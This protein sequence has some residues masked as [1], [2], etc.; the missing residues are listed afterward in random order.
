MNNLSKTITRRMARAAS[1][2]S[3]LAVAGWTGHAAAG[4]ICFPQPMFVPGLSG[5]PTWATAPSGTPSA[6]VLTRPDLNEPRW[7]SSPL[8][9][10]L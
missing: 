6:G 9:D 2:A 7:A 3:F 4:P 10:F 1:M 5:P 8:T